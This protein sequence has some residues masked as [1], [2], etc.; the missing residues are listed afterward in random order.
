MIGPR[1]IIALISNLGYKASLID[2]DSSLSSNGDQ[3]KEKKFWKRKVPSPPDARR[4]Y[5]FPN[6]SGFM[7]AFT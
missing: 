6:I 5:L 2:E 4:L 7:S 1:S 3:G